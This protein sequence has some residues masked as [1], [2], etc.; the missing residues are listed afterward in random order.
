MNVRSKQEKVRMNKYSKGVITMIAGL[1]IVAITGIIIGISCSTTGINKS[2]ARYQAMINSP[3]WKE[4]SFRN[5]L[6]QQSSSMGKMFSQWIGSETE[7]RVPATP[8]P[9]QKRKK[10]DYN[11]PPASGLRVTWMGHSSLLIEI[12]GQKVLIDPMWSD[13]A[14]PV[15]FA[16]PKRFFPPPL[17]LKELPVLDAIIISH[18]HFDHLDKETIIALKDRVP[19][20]AVPLGVGV[21]LE[22]WGVD[23]KKI[24][25]RDWWE[26]VKTGKLILTATPARH[27]SG[28]SITRIYL[29]ETLWCGWSIAGPKHHVFY[30]G[31]TAMFPG[32]AE[33]GRRL[34]PFD[35]TLIES[36]AYN[37]L[38]PDVHMGPEQAVEAHIM[39]R[40]KVMM[41]VHWGTF[42]LA[43]HNWTEPA[44]RLMAASKKHGIRLVIPRPGEIFDTV[45]PPKLA[46]WWPARPWQN[47]MEAP[48]NSTGIDPLVSPRPYKT[49]EKPAKMRKVTPEN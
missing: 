9:I 12:D 7:Y 28:R 8:V 4:G 24:I 20:F 23:P 44:E 17:P 39:L 45:N 35:L 38:W 3:Q 21:Y 25:E 46:R 13:R 36:G 11:T 41:P 29:N 30:S 6:K 1:I 40:G 26:E 2:G 49:A 15:S 22:K 32:F 42:D 27:F 47:A 14:S 43:L 48:V 16:G 34:G 10:E 31:D 37:S 5:P 18:D 19:L 33:I